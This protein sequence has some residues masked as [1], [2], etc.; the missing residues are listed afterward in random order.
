MRIAFTINPT[1]I[2]YSVMDKTLLDKKGLE[3]TN[4]AT[5]GDMFALSKDEADA[6]SVELDNAINALCLRV[7][8]LIWE[9]NDGINIEAESTRL[10]APHT[11]AMFTE[12]ALY[13][14]MLAWWY[15]SRHAGLMAQA[16]ENAKNAVLSLKRSLE[17]NMT[18]RPHRYF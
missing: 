16:Q 2:F 7:P 11:I 6:F 18:T 13:Y 3:S 1:D 10:I 5:L 12:R 8:Q 14:T 17:P 15:E 9:P 4:G